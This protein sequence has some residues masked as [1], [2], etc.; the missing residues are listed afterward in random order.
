M[1][2]IRT[3]SFK[4]PL[5]DLPAFNSWATQVESI[6]QKKY[7]TR[8]VLTSIGNTHVWT[9]N[10]E[11]KSKECLLI[12]PGARTSVL[13]W[14]LDNNLNHF[15]TS[16]RIFLVETNGLPNPSDGATPDIKS[17]D[18]GIWAGEIMNQLGIDKCHI[19]GASFGG[20]ICMKL[21]IVHPEKV[22]KVFLLNPGCLQPFSLKFSNLYYNL[23]PIISP[24][25]KNVVAFLDKAVFCKPQHTLS[26][27]AMNLLIDYE[28][29]A[30]TKY[31]DKTQKPYYMNDEL[32]K[33]RS[34]TYLLT[35]DHD[36]LFPATKSVKNAREKLSNLKDAVIY[37]NVAHGIETYD[38]AMKYISEKISN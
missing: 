9:L 35:G 34:E 15:G 3:S 10:E 8:T 33:V 37:E 20:L 29:M 18:W 32:K 5:K 16:V 1:K 22:K 6:N 24:K 23:L 12:F 21:A 36:T 13:F 2:I 4:N 19:A 25:R 7:G 26:N 27:Q 17:N 11:S 28:V 38:K 30:L 14:D 31:N